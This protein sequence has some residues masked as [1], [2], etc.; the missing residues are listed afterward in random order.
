MTKRKKNMTG[1]RPDI[2]GAATDRKRH[3]RTEFS[4]TGRNRRERY[5]QTLIATA[6]TTSKNPLI[7]F[8]AKN[9]ILNLQAHPTSPHRQHE[10]ESTTDDAVIQK[11]KT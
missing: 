9:H 8:F 3:K 5:S 7:N 11:E 2:N 10:E 4:V 1:T 6:P